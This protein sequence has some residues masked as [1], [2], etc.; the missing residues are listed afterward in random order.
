MN[1]GEEIKRLR[2]QVKTLME[3]LRYWRLEV[4]LNPT[5]PFKTTNKWCL[6]CKRGID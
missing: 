2:A 4:A 1:E 6:T 3:E 5:P